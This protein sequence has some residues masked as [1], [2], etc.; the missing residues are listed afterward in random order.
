MQT[1]DQPTYDLSM[2]INGVSAGSLLSEFTSF[3]RYLQGKLTM[4]TTMRG[5]LDDT[6]G[7]IT[8]T[9]T[10]QGHA[11]IES[12]TLSGWKVNSAIAS[13]L[14]LPDMEQINFK[15]WSNEFSISDGRVNIKDLKIAAL[16]ADYLVNGSQG[17]DGSMDYRV[18]MLLSEQASAKVSI[19]GFVGE[20]LNLFKDE[21]GRVK[22]DLS[23]GGMSANPSVALDTRQMQ[24]RAEEAA[25]QKLT[26]EGK[27][28][29][30]QVKQKG[31]DLLKDL[32][33]KKK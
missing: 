27:K 3:G 23:V 33:K 31:E 29:Q 1:P 30:D 19:P 10:G 16:G 7:L 17:L 5:A 15:D 12:G 20:A 9:L 26:D 8:Q 14:K 24:L 25:K 11:Q 28:L 18:S 21:S 32:F 4:N 6:L 13:L 22:L 2:D